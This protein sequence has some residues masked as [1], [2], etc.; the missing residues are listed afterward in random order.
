MN[1][2]GL[3]FQA[4]LRVGLLDRVLRVVGNHHKQVEEHAL[5]IAL[6]Q[7]EM[8]GPAAAAEAEPGQLIGGLGLIVSAH[9]AEGALEGNGHGG[10]RRL[11]A[12][13]VHARNH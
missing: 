5:G 10:V 1:S 12:N 3:V 13:G 4:D 8:L 11:A 7:Q 2:A 6:G 9:G